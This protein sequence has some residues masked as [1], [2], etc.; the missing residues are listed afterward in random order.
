MRPSNRNINQIRPVSIKT[1]IIK[2]AEGSCNIK[3]GN[4]EIICT[5]T[6][7]ENVPHFIRKTGLGWVT[8]EYGMLP[9][10]TNSRMKRESSRG[11]QGG[12]TLEIQRL[13][14][15]SLRTCVDRLLLGER[16]IIID[17]DVMQ[18]DGG[19]RCA[20]ITGG[21]IALKLASDH[22][23]KNQ[24]I[25]ENPNIPSEA[26]IAIKNI[27]SNS[28]LVNFVSSNMNISVSEKYKILQIDNH[29]NRAIECLR[30]MNVEFQKL[31]LKNDIQDI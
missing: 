31:S 9:R 14:G 15:R 4:T 25:D 18:A 2:N 7:D 12:R 1:D 3:C 29:Q 26:S 13:I 5:A 20:A 16:Q 8:A 24:I 10:S 28:F 23:V 21:W 27:Q 30:Y 22:L 19:T 17:C 6:I 11:K